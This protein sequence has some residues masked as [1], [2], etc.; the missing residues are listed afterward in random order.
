MRYLQA[1]GPAVSS[2]IP[3]SED[4]GHP[5]ETETVHKYRLGQ[6]KGYFQGK[7]PGPEEPSRAGSWQLLQPHPFQLC[8]KARL[9]VPKGTQSISKVTTVHAW[10][11]GPGL[12]C[13]SLSGSYPPF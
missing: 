10:A 8:G 2:Y 12:P 3:I 1:P 9:P 13:H 5:W 11:A 7:M 6:N 4:S